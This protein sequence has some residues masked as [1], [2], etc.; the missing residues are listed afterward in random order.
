MKTEKQKSETENEQTE[1]DIFFQ[2]L[3]LSIEKD[4]D[5]TEALKRLLE[6]IKNDVGCE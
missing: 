1:D 6:E 5:R 3:Q 2:E 4:R